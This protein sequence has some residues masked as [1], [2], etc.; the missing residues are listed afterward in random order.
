[1]EPDVAAEIIIQAICPRCKQNYTQKTEYWT[2]LYDLDKSDGSRRY[3][4]N[5]FGAIKDALVNV[6][7]RKN[8]CP[9]CTASTTID[10]SNES[11]VAGEGK[12]KGWPQR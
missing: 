8:P 7:F 11:A 10:G 9:M 2:K 12:Y 3:L 6:L 4:D 5:H 1:M